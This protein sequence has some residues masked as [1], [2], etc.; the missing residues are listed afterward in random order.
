[1]GAAFYHIVGRSR[2]RFFGWFLD[3]IRLRLG[4][5]RSSQRLICCLR[6]SVEPLDLTADDFK[7]LAQQ[8][9]V[10][11]ERRGKRTY[12]KLRLRRDGK[13]LVRYLGDALRAASVQD[14]LN[15]LQQQ[16]KL[17]QGLKSQGKLAKR[18]L[19]DSKQQLQPLLEAKG[20]AFH[21]LAIRRLKKES[22]DV[23]PATA[24]T[25]TTTEES[26]MTNKTLQPNAPG[27]APRADECN[28]Q[29]TV[30]QPDDL[31]VAC[32]ARVL[33]YLASSLREKD[34]LEANLASINSGLMDFTLKYESI[35]A[36]ALESGP[37]TGC[38][39]F[40][41]RWMTI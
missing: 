18:M 14:E 15:R 28:E 40:D 34:P 10:S 11:P 21:G 29:A 32:S 1:L 13:Q 27:P 12:F 41:R 16:H 35:L 6:H 39:K 26:L 8:G 5:R 4:L 38:R 24:V 17:M 22:V 37:Q 36:Q 25:L 9:F 31:Q 3:G 20:L 30:P 7:Q 19:R 33:E 23:S 2:G